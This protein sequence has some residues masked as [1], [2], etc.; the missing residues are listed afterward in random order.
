MLSRMLGSAP[1]SEQQAHHLRVATR[2][3]QVERRDFRAPARPAAVDI[4]AVG[5]QPFHRRH[6]V[7]LRHQVQR[8]ATRIDQCR[9]SR[10]TGAWPCP[11]RPAQE[12]Q[13]GPS[14]RRAADDVRDTALTSSADTIAPIFSITR[15]SVSGARRVH[16]HRLT[17][18]VNRQWI[19]AEFEQQRDHLLAIHQHGEVQRRPVVFVA[20]LPA[21]EGRR[22]GRHDTAHF[23]RKVHRDRGED[24]V[25][26]AAAHEKIRNG[27]MRGVVAS[28]PARRPADDLA[29]RGRHRA[30]RRHRPRRPAAA[31]RPGG[32]LPRPSASRRC[33]L[34]SRGC[35]RPGRASAAGPR[36]PGAR[37]C[38][39]RCS[40]VHSYGFA[41]ACSLSGCLSSRAVRRVTSPFRAA[42]N[43]WPSTVS[44]STCAL[45]ARQLE[46]PYCSGELELRVGELR[47][48]VGLAQFFET[49]LR[50]LAE[51][52]EIGVVGQRQ[53]SGRRPR[54][55]FGH[56]TPSF[57]RKGQALSA[58]VVRSLGEEQK[59]MEERRGRVEPFTRT[60]GRPRGTWPDGT[61]RRGRHRKI[62]ERPF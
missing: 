2:S 37:C 62:D 15:R 10:G 30:R 18:A 41:R 46:N 25:P 26:R 52:I 43:S 12:A 38:A 9:D 28:V 59:V 31:R 21:V 40:S 58:P 54:G 39:A 13:R 11:N 42:S 53:R 61:P 19:G 14:G 55:L 8:P 1:A 50:L 16:R 6:V 44:E 48:R 35:S 29:A 47:G 3:G 20:T 5:E 57:L 23:V 24:V 32:R 22:V 7:A 17:R 4:C 51:P 60:V 49:A 33:C 45:S 56:E 34:P 27:A 36:P